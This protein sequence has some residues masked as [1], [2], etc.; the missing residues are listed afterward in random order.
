MFK[1]TMFGSGIKK[2]RSLFRFPKSIEQQLPFP[3]PCLPS[4]L[5]LTYRFS[6]PS[7]QITNLCRHGDGRQQ[8]QTSVI[9]FSPYAE[10]SDHRQLPA[11]HHC[12]SQ[13][14]DNA[15]SIAYFYSNVYTCSGCRKDFFL[16]CSFLCGILEYEYASHH[17]NCLAVYIS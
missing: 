15:Q 13:G 1:F 3:P 10:D 14:P 7:S 5:L 16:L 6:I 4:F 11:V 17:R 8:G 12:S 9:S 2:K